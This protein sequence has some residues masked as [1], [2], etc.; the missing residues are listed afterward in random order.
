MKKLVD[1]SSL[2]QITHKVAEIADKLADVVPVTLKL[3]LEIHEVLRCRRCP[4]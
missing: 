2:K 4:L 1:F 3:F